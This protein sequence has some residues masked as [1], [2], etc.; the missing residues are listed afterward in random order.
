M[1]ISEVM[2]NVSEVM[3]TIKKD[4]KIAKAGRLMW[5]GV[6]LYSVDKVIK[7]TRQ[8]GR[9]DSSKVFIEG[10]EDLLDEM[11]KESGE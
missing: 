11:E 4:E 3:S 1:K 7:H 2:G 8:L 5:L 6:G 10:M 9:I